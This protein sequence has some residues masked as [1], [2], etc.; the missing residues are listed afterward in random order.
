[1]KKAMTGFR[2]NVACK[3]S[4]IKAL[5]GTA[6]VMA[7]A[8]VPGLA[9]AQSASE[10]GTAASAELSGAQTIIL[11]LLVTLVGIVFLFVVYK[12]IKKAN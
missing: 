12:L 9:L 4:R 11:G 3:A 6:M 5:L 10:L 8:S 1:M 7:M 2:A